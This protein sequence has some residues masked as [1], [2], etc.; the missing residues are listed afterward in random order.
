M[1]D[2]DLE[3]LKTIIENLGDRLERTKGDQ[4]SRDELYR[5]RMILNKMSG[6]I[7]KG[8]S[9][10]QDR[11]TI[12]SELVKEMRKGAPR[13]GTGPVQSPTTKRNTIITEEKTRRQGS[14]D[15]NTILDQILRKAGSEANEF[16]DAVDTAGKNTKTFGERLAAAN[17]SF[18]AVA[19]SASAFVAKSFSV[20]AERIDFYRQLMATGEGS[21]MSMQDM[22]RQASAAGMTVKQFVEAMS[23][24]T[25]GARQLGA[26]KFGD[27]RKSLLEMTRASGYMGMLPDQ[28][29]E[30]TSTYAEILR[31]QGAGQNRSSEQMAAGILNLVKTSETTAHILGKTREEALEAQKLAAADYQ[32]NAVADSKGFDAQAANAV[33]DIFKNNFGDVGVQA[34]TDQLTFGQVVNKPAA[35]L[36]A[37]NP[38]L[39]KALAL[40]EGMLRNGA[41]S[42][43][44]QLEVARAL[45]ENGANLAK[46]KDLQLQFAQQA[47]LDNN[48]LSGALKSVLQNRFVSQSNNTDGDFNRA[49]DQNQNNEQRAATGALQLAESFNKAMVTIDSGVTAVFNPM[50]DMLGPKLRDDILPSMDAFNVKLQEAA[51]SASLQTNT[52]GSIGTA[53]LAVAGGLAIFSGGL[54]AAAGS[55]KLFRGLSSV[56]GSGGRGASGIGRAAGA[57]GGAGRFAGLARVA[58]P[59]LGIAGGVAAGIGGMY[60]SG[61]QIQ[62]RKGESFTGT[63]AN[64]KGFF[65]S[66][67]S[68]YLTSILSGAGSGALAGSAFAGVG[69]IPG[70][71]LGGLTGLGGAIYNDWDNLTGSSDASQSPRAARAGSSA[72]M[73]RSRNVAAPAD[74]TGQR[75]RT[76][77]TVDQMTNRIMEASER[78]TGLLKQ[79]KDNSDRHLEAVREEIAVIRNMSDRMDRLLQEGNKNTKSIAEHS[80]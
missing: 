13:P 14:T 38:D 46:N 28:I 9:T 63:G 10:T 4:L 22:G 60:L 43:Q 64:E 78:S 35:E 48:P 32:F 31:L 5:I 62:S 71:V 20:G 56:L 7:G 80:F 26:I 47:Q 40:A 30:V 58:A 21:V 57:A 33:R 51:M 1:A 70:A 3:Q 8:D 50:V 29:T 15:G 23:N 66:R 45:K 6:S 17:S 76:S 19:S 53:A 77:L 27:V 79:I 36:A 52:M 55:L 24:G 41:S 37:V 69:A 16:S 2:F 59:A 42:D 65:G 49:S 12:I 18:G 34:I 11:K 39:Q 44:V 73:S 74:A 68:S 72:P 67:S 61:E 54:T 75:S 25:Q